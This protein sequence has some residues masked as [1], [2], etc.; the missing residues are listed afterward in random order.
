M[1]RKEVP[2]VPP[3]KQ[4]TLMDKIHSCQKHG[5]TLRETAEFLQVD[6]AR[7]CICVE[8]WLKQ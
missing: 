4:M 5:W 1:T 7:I 3:W 6:Y 2:Y 8:G